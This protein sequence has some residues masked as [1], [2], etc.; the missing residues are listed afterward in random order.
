MFEAPFD[1]EYQIGDLE[2]AESD[3][4]VTTPLSRDPLADE[5]VRKVLTLLQEQHS[6][7]AAFVSELHGNSRALAAQAGATGT[8]SGIHDDAT[9]DPHAMVVCRQIFGARPAC[10]IR[11][12]VVLANGGFYGALYAPSKAV[13]EEDR[14][15]DA[16]LIEMT[17]KLTARLVDTRQSPARTAA[18]NDDQ[19]Q[20][21]YA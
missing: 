14:R 13:S 7:E 10:F 1:Y 3:F 18:A 19:P 17:A 11:V 2:V 16:A 12:P 9:G 6:V 4:V 15:R 20:Q 21:K 8:S 5:T